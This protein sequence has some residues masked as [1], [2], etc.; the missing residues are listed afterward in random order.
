MIFL[1][2]CIHITKVPYF[3]ICLVDLMMME[4]TLIVLQLVSL[5]ELSLSQ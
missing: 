4:L 5:Q 2:V 3:V 1:C